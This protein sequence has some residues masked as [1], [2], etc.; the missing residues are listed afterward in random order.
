LEELIMRS[1]LDGSRHKASKALAALSVLTVL[2]LPACYMEVTEDDDD[3]DLTTRVDRSGFANPEAPNATA[4]TCEEPATLGESANGTP[5]CWEDGDY[6]WRTSCR[7]ASCRPV[8]VYAHYMLSNDLGDARVVHVEAFDNEHFQGAPVGTVT[9]GDFP[10]RTGTWRDSELYLEP[11]EYYLR[12]YL[13]T[14]DAVVVPYVLGDMQLVGA[15]PVGVYGALSGAQAVRVEPRQ[16]DQFTDP[17]HIY[18]DKLFE[19]PGDAPDTHAHLRADLKVQEGV[20]VPD[21]REV[22]INLYSSSDL[23]TKPVYE[24]SMP[25]ALFLVQGRVGRAEFVTPSLAE[26]AYVVYAWVD[27]DS[28]G[29]ADEDE[30]SG[31]FQVDGQAKKVEIVKD[32]TE[33]VALT[34]AGP[35]TEPTP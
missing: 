15:A 19:K 2:A 16:M 11:G 7:A 26:G 17:V 3:E 35:E 21:G 24:F 30:A 22:R 1:L 34:L 33:S 13:T 18:L 31:L 28:D 10:A 23:A 32:R 8:K 14:S 9:I 4:D 29:F 27:A 20:V 5:Y 12:A 6:K 25:S